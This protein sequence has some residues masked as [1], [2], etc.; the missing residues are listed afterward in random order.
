MLSSEGSAPSAPRH[1]STS[2]NMQQRVRGDVPQGVG[3]WGEG[4]VLTTRRPCGCH[5][6]P[7]AA[8]GHMPPISDTEP[9]LGLSGLE[10]EVLLR[11]RAL[12]RDVLDFI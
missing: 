1:A 11:R 8:E 2:A 5:Y 9:R 3:L 7:G 12:L 4:Q 10:T 6:P